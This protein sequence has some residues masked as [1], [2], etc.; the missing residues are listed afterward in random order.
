MNPTL[1]L[2]INTL[3]FSRFLGG[4]RLLQKGKLLIMGKVGK[5]ENDFSD[6]ANR[7]NFGHYFSF[8]FG[9]LVTFFAGFTNSNLVLDT[10][11]F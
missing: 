2:I 6:R 3:C 1:S 8:S 10:H 11:K 5:D 9:V 4:L 7:L